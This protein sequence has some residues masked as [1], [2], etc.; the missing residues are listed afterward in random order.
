RRF[1]LLT[2]QIRYPR[3]AERSTAAKKE[4]QQTAFKTGASADKSV[5]PSGAAYWSQGDNCAAMS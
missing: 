4:P 5:E 1:I 3:T 2:A